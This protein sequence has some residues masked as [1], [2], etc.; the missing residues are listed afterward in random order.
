MLK[1][2]KQMLVEYGRKRP[3][4]LWKLEMVLNYIKL[5]SWMEVNNF[6][7]PPG[8]RLDSRED[9]FESVVKIINNK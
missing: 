4:T 3:H 8:K 1:L 5:G 9:V 2:F 7:I 6:Y